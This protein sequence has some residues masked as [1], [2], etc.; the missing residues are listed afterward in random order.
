MRVLWFSWEQDQCW[1]PWRL[2]ASFLLCVGS[3][4]PTVMATV[5]VLTCPWH[6]D[7]CA[8]QSKLASDLSGQGLGWLNNPSS[9]YPKS[10]L[11]AVPA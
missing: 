3:G 1:E 11:T 4:S 7:K 9:F 10:C 8:A 2:P 6:L 5:F